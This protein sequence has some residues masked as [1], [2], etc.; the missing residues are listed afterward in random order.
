[1]ADSVDAFVAEFNRVNGQAG[2]ATTAPAAPLPPP[3]PNGSAVALQAVVTPNELAKNNAPCIRLAGLDWPIPLLA[4]RQNRHVVPAVS[5][6]TKRMRDTA[7]QKLAQ[8]GEETKA[9]IL[10]NADPDE[11]SRRGTDAVL[12]ER[13]WKITD[14]SFEMAHSLEPEFFDTVCNALYWALTRAHPQLTR[15]Q[16]DDMPM[17]ML[18]MIDCIGIVAQQ[19]GMMKRVEPSAAPLADPNAAASPS[20]PTST[21]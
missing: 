19:T 8:L 14:F 13:I 6:I 21:P 17:G 7:E 9:A 16:F 11:V 12:R 15:Q 4:P 10:Q 20:P 2:P 3:F 1:M 18:E 5:K